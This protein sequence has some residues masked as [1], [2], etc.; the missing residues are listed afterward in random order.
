V[1]GEAAALTALLGSS[2]KFRGPFQLQT[3]SDG[4]IEMIVVDFD[5]PDRLR[6]YARYDKE[7]ASRDRSD[8]PRAADLWASASCHDHRPGAEMNRTRR[9]AR[10]KA[11]VSRRPRTS[12]S[13]NPS[14]SRRACGSAVG[15]AVRERA[16][17]LRAGGLLVQFLPS[18]ARADAPA[19]LPPATSRRAIPPA[20]QAR[21]PRTTPGSEAR[22]L[23]DT[24]EDHELVDPGRVERAAAL[25]SLP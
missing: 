2:L 16:A 25:P 20:T 18:L 8:G 10:S 7:R 12:I 24:V 5:A 1:V 9:G 6:A 13:A 15:G 21:R 22:A 17:L 4:P 11:R 14:R 23:V 19:D 3:K